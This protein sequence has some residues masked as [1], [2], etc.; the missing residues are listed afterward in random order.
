MTGPLQR[1]LADKLRVKGHASR[2][3]EYFTLIGTIGESIEHAFVI[4][5]GPCV[6]TAPISGELVCFANDLDPAYWNNFGS[7]KLSIVQT[8]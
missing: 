5:A 8:V 4:G 3:A 7:M 1:G 6:F 2:K